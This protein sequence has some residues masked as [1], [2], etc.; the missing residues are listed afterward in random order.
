M[1]KAKDMIKKYDRNGDGSLDE[2][3]FAE[4]K[5]PN[6]EKRTQRL[7]LLRLHHNNYVMLLVNMIKMVMDH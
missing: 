1:Q 5:K 3:E 2:Q 6:S 4:L 7:K